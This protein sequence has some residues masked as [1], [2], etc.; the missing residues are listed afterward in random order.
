VSPGSGAATP[1]RWTF[2]ARESH[3]RPSPVRAV[4]ELALDP[5]YAAMTG[6]N[7]DTSL[8]PGER[9]GE[10]TARLLRD[11]GPEILQYGSGAGLSTLTPTVQGL[12][13]PLGSHVTSDNLLI[14]TGSQMGIDLSTKLLC[15]PGDVVLAEG[16]T[17]VGA[18]GVFGAYEVDEQG[19]IPEAEAAQLDDLA[20]S[21]RPARFVYCIPHHQNPSGV[22]LT[23]HRRRELVDVCGQRGVLIVEDDPYAYC[24]FPG[25]DPL[26]SMHSM[27]PHGVVYLGSMSKLFS[28]GLRVGWMCAP[29]AMRGR[30]QIAGESVDIHPTVLAQELVRE[31]VGTPEWESTL[32]TQRTAYQQRCGYTMD[33]LARELT[34]DITWTRPSGGFFTWLTLPGVDPA[35]DILACA[36]EQRLVVVPGGACY[37]R[38]PA[39]AHVRLAYS[40]STREQVDEAARRLAV[41][42]EVLR[43]RASETGLSCPDAGTK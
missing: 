35:A 8:L 18:M 42:I 26:P 41:T 9:L 36:I 28:P 23:L 6:G 32:L 25:V 27:N 1:P 17:Y 43:S 11:R 31:W 13:E 2:A 4:F 16:P 5:D 12:M 22:T 40:N 14:T 3:F 30:L 29:P 19:R 15:D 24:G 38:Q 33:A 37:A 7:P 10:I 21:G 20:A 39:A 34:D